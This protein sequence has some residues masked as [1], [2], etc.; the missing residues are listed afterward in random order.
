MIY[1]HFPS[2]YIY[3]NLDNSE[4]QSADGSTSPTSRRKKKVDRKALMQQTKQVSS[5]TKKAYEID[6]T[7]APETRTEVF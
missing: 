6:D 4:E 5:I 3:I 2:K 1:P 7:I